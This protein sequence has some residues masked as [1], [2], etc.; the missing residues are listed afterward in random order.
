M[1]LLS[2]GGSSTTTSSSQTTETGPS[3]QRRRQGR[4]DRSRG[5]DNG[6]DARTADDVAATENETAV[7]APASSS[8]SSPVVPLPLCGVIASFSGQDQ[9]RKLELQRI[10]CSLGGR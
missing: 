2:P 6:N 8:L 3:S 10:L 1:K 7:A 9:T 4:M 5:D